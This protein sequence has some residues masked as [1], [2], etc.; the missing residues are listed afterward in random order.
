MCEEGVCVCGCGS[1]ESGDACC[2]L[3]RFSSTLQNNCPAVEQDPVF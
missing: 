3:L 1:H 2:N